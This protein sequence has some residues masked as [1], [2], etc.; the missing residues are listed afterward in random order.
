MMQK[1]TNELMQETILL[2][3]ASIKDDITNYGDAE[4]N[5]KNAEAIKIL[6]EAYDIV[7]G[8]NDKQRDG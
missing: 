4:E 8:T 5:Q 1:T 6:A 2:A 7:C 3:M